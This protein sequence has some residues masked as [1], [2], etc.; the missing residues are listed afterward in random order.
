M[1]HSLFLRNVLRLGGGTAIGQLLSV[2]ATPVIT[3]IYSP[4]DM[5]LLGVFMAFVGFVSV[6][7]ALRYEMPIISVRDNCE[8]D[9]LLTSSLFLTLPMSIFAGLI[10]Y[11][12][13]TNNIFSYQLLPE[14]S[15]AIAVLFLLLSGVFTSLRYWFVRRGEYDVIGRALVYQGFGRAT[16]PITLGL[17]QAG[18][19]SLLLSE[20]M[21]RALGISR[22][23]RVAWPAIIGSMRPF[24]LSY[25]SLILRRNWKSPV[26][27]LPSSLIDALAAMIPLPI[28][29]YLFG[30]E[31]AG[32]FFLVQRLSSLPAGFIASS[33][34]D[35][36]HP[37]IANAHWSEPDQIRNILVKV[38]KKLALTSVLIYMPITLISPF[39]FGFIFG[40][41]WYAAGICM[42]IICPLSMV[43]LVVSP[44]SRLL[45]VVD[46]MEVKF[47][48]DIISLIVPIGGMFVMNYLGCNFYTC[49]GV[50]VVFHIL[51]NFIYYWLIWRASVVDVVADNPL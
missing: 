40:Q 5:G 14:W 33:V 43:S 35:V 46:K 48:F 21:S 1:P 13:I 50:Y 30:P 31:A 51:S 2:I 16:L 19:I 20:I 29:S 17:A 39:V 8:A 12:L 38:T 4:V 10:M 7:V 27:L 3:R 11:V 42:A 47:V 37:A 15:A 28:V 36:F 9:C 45:L 34:A 49:L 22:M 23:I 24:S 41:E 26:I 18:W 6:G 32:Q 25:F 44:T